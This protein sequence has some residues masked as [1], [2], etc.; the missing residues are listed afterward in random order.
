MS[1][2]RYHCVECKRVNWDE[3]AA[4]AAGRCVVFGIDVA[5]HDFVG[6]LEVKGGEPLARIKWQHPAETPGLLA[7]LRRLREGGALEAVL[8]S[9]GTYGDAL[10][11]QLQELGATIY[12]VGAKRVH[13]AAEVFDGV[14]SLHDAKSAD[15]I[16]Y[17]H[18][19]GQSQPWVTAD[20]QRRALN[21][22]LKMLHQTKERQQQEIN[23][24][25]A[26]LSRHWPESL[27]LLGLGSATLHH[28]IADY[29][30]PKY[31]QAFPELAR[32][33]MHR[34]GRSKVPAEKIAAV[35]AS[36]ATTLGMPCLNE[37][38]EWLRWQAKAV[39]TTT[40][41]VRKLERRITELV[42]E[43]AALASVRAVVGAV[44]SAVLFASAGNP[45]DYPDADSYCKAFGLNLT[46]RSSGTHQGRLKIT[47]RGPAVARFY[48]YF[49]ALR[50]LAKDEG[51][52]KWFER[53][54]ARPGAI[55]GKQIVELMRKLIKGL[56]HHAHGRPFQPQR[57]FDQQ[58]A[59][60]AA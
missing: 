32:D 23:R 3:L 30:G 31:V 40:E 56:W 60:L 19:L 50:L 4:Q 18:Q 12:R 15:L 42:A 59:P 51:V 43:D 57:L 35:I 39:L 10:R 29:G 14:P 20:D 27:E 41:E 44:T 33:L 49:V 24:L 58:V 52:K 36:A 1:K 47:K 37:E 13:D 7:G 5:K 34:I 6:A 9:T 48:L 46:E 25:E 38:V 22:R 11:W 8:E 45:L 17:L 55:K 21:A 2:S 54:T 28:L 16:A 26:L 53:K